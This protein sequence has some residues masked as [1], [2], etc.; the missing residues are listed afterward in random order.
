MR[1]TS[2]LDTYGWTSSKA[3]KRAGSPLSVRFNRCYLIVIIKEVMD[4]VL[5]SHQFSQERLW[6]EFLS[7]F[8]NAHYF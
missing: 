4:E 5:S 7:N 1:G 3:R 8:L 6:S 2:S